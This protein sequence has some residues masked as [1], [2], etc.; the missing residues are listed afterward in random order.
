MERYGH[1]FDKIITFENMYESYLEARKGRK[2]KPEILRAGRN[3]E[4]TIREIDLNNKKVLFYPV[5]R[6]AT[7]S[8]PQI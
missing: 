3:I 6:L 7:H 5:S 4:K 8:L 1:L 2:L